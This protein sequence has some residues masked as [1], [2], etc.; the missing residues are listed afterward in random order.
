MPGF[1]DPVRKYCDVGMPACTPS[2]PMDCASTCVV[3]TAAAAATAMGRPILP[4]TGE[5]VAHFAAA[6]IATATA[7]AISSRPA[8][9]TAAGAGRLPEE[10]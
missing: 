7:T 2:T 10:C 5:A 9:A 8:P 3:A 1:Q 6:A 4:R